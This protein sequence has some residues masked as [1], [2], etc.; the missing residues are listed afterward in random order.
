MT[1]NALLEAR[2]GGCCELCKATESLTAYE[3][4]GGSDIGADASVHL[5]ATCKEL[6][7]DDVTRNPHHFMCLNDSMWTPVP[8]VQVLAWRIL[9]TLAAG[10]SWAQNALDMLYLDDELMAWAKAGLPD[11]N[12]EPTLDANG[13]VL[14][15]GDTVTLIKDLDVKGAGFTAKR[16]TVVRGISLTDN[17]KHLE[18]KVNG[19]RIVLVAAY[20]KKA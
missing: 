17:P 14:Q 19:T 13:A 15:A 1:V 11:E 10:E 5:C 12:A 9:H 20:C 18:G 8:A 4:T 2:S 16:G 7:D 3:V 6:L